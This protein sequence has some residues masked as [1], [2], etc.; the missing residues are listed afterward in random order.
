MNLTPAMSW[1]VA[2]V[3]S[4]KR[5][6]YS[7]PLCS[8]EQSVWESLGLFYKPAEEGDTSMPVDPCKD[9]TLFIRSAQ[10]IVC[11]SDAQAVQPHA[12]YD[13][14]ANIRRGSGGFMTDSINR[15]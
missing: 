15:F 11:V 12:V 8:Y 13:Q 4:G 5:D 9:G 2:E 7:Q 14:A 10:Y 1:Q 3:A 6:V